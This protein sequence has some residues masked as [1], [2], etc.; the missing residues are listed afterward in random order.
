MILI[1]KKMLVILDEDDLIE[2]DNEENGI[3]DL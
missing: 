2:Y 1:T 3:P